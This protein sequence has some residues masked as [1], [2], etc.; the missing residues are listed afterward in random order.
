MT[1][2]TVPVYD[3]THAGIA[4]LPPGQHA[5]YATGTGTV[6]WTAADWAAHPGAVRIDQSPVNTALDE[7]CDVLDM[8]RG[9]ATIADCAPWAEGA[10][11]NFAAAR[12]PGQRH[13]AIYMSLSNVT[14]VVNALVT[15]G[16]TSGPGLWIANW[17]LTEPEA[18][19]LVAFAA[20]PFPVIGVQYGT[21][22]D[23]D[24]S[25]FSAAWLAAVSGDL[26]A[27]AGWHGEYVT[28]GLFSLAQ[29]AAKLGVPP[30]ALLRMTAVHYG[31]LGN[32]LA[33]Y[34]NALH[35][36]TQ[37]ASAPVP[38]GVKLWVD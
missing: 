10:A 36:G 12:R 35:G 23:Y 16:I 9:A 5:G 6:P 24:V 21:R 30:S 22:G 32:Q 3:A 19:A 15:A 4:S 26:P 38:A 17:N 28:A 14:P 8:E 33:A 2:A 37:P 31:T 7:L 20:G 27:P 1:I 34:E 13:P 29:L 11:A 25:V 18:R